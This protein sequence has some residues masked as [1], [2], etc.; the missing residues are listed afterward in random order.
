MQFHPRS[1]REI[2]VTPMRH[3]AVVVTL[4]GNAV[5]ANEHGGKLDIKEKDVTDKVENKET[6]KDSSSATH[7]IVPLEDEV[8]QFC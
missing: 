6:P 5:S 3:A 1:E 7:C 4:S 2:L 8:L